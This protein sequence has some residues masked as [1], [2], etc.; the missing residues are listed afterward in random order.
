MCPHEWCPHNESITKVMGSLATVLTL[1]FY[2]SLQGAPCCTSSTQIQY[3]CLGAHYFCNDLITR[4]HFLGGPWLLYK[5]SCTCVYCTS[6][7]TI[8]TVMLGGILFLASESAHIIVL[9]TTIVESG[10]K[11]NTHHC[12]FTTCQ[13]PQSTRGMC[14]LARKWKFPFSKTG[15]LRLGVLVS[16]PPFAILYS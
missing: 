13:I 7:S 4:P 14:R 10:N 16:C 15:R 3:C 9:S 8:V 11:Y 2:S 6:T 5:Y 1:H 12:H